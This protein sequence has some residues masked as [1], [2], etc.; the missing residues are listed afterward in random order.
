MYV[1]GIGVPNMPSVSRDL[2][3][4]NSVPMTLLYWDRIYI[5][6]PFLPS[7]SWAILQELLHLK[8]VVCRNGGK[9]AIGVPSVS[10]CRN[11][12]FWSCF[13]AIGVLFMP[14]GSLKIDYTNFEFTQF[15]EGPRWREKD[16]D[17]IGAPFSPSGSQISCRTYSSSSHRCPF[18]GI[19]VPRHW[20]SIVGTILTSVSCFQHRCPNV[21]VRVFYC[22]KHC[23]ACFQSIKMSFFFECRVFLLGGFCSLSKVVEYIG[24]LGWLFPLLSLVGL[25]YLFSSGCMSCD[26]LKWR[27]LVT[28][29]GGRYSWGDQRFTVH[30]QELLFCCIFSSYM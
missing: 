27:H 22:C 19:G 23:I 28:P 18:F 20:L 17:S 25:S 29:L 2:N 21:H 14:S 24:E 6:V 12:F 15:G 5:G 8:P 7:V 9:L 13:F 10:C 16:P 3:V 11:P 1:F 26:R 30:T 4:R